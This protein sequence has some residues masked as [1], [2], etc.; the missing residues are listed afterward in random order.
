MDKPIQIYSEKNQFILVKDNNFRLSLS[1]LNGDAIPVKEFKPQSAPIS[2]YGIVGCVEAKIQKYMIYIDE[3]EKIGEFLEAPVYRIKLFKYIPYDTDNISPED[4]TY[5]QMI[6]DFLERNPL[7]Y[8]DKV[9]LS[10]SFQYIRKRKEDLLSP[11][12]TIF[13]FSN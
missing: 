5:I 3:V 11:H 12:S 1:K 6:N 9:D 2:C 13:R 4:S 8:S 7:F 10:M